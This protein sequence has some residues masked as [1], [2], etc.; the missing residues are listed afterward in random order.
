MKILILDDD[1][2]RHTTYAQE[3]AGHYVRHVYTYFEF[4]SDLDGGSPWDLIHLD[5][6]LGDL[7]TGDT[8]VDGW[9][10]TCEYNGRHAARAICE[11]PDNRLPSQVIIQ[12][13]NPVGAKAMLQM[14]QR[15]EVAVEWQPFG[16][17][18]V[19]FGA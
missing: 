6:D 8:Y 19:N 2:V 7:Q 1:Q 4:L 11:L 5:H 15:R 18:S 12:S 10:S 9:G 13:V 14:L 17:S 3:Y 16:E